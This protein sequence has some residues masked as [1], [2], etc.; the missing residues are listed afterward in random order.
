MVTKKINY[1]DAFSAIDSDSLGVLSAKQFSD[2]LGK[3]I[4]LSE[5][6][7]YGLFALIDKLGTGLDYV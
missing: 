5:P 6:V 2:G 7:K 3:Y 4:E 1:Y